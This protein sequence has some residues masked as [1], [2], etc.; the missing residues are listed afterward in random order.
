[1]MR[2]GNMPH[3]RNALNNAVLTIPRVSTRDD[4]H[5]PPTGVPDAVSPRCLHRPTSFTSPGKSMRLSHR[6]SLVSNCVP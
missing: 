6:R 5:L 2:Y 3:A 4:Q 1:M